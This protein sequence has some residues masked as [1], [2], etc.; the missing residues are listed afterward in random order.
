MDDI[1]VENLG[2]F[3][4]LQHVFRSLHD[5]KIFFTIRKYFLFA[6]VIFPVNSLRAKVCH[7]H[8]LLTT[9]LLM[10]NQVTVNNFLDYHT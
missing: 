10:S 3:L 1:V 8:I 7:D 6:N 2:S 5:A 9:S 4:S